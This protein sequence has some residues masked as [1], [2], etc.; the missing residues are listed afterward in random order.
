MYAPEILSAYQ[1]SGVLSDADEELDLRSLIQTRLKTLRSNIAQKKSYLSHLQDLGVDEITDPEERVKVVE[2]R[3]LDCIF[4][5]LETFLLE[6]EAP[7]LATAAARAALVKLLC[8]RMRS[9]SDTDD[10]IV[11]GKRIDVMV[12]SNSLNA[13]DVSPRLLESLGL[14]VAA[15]SL[16]FHSGQIDVALESLR[17]LDFGMQAD[18]SEA[19]GVQAAIDILKEIGN[20]EVL[21]KHSKWLLAAHPQRALAALT[22]PKNKIS[23][24]QPF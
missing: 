6:G 3:A 5:Y 2:K 10:R 11:L 23:L 4:Q 1:F 20:A 8:R 18:A 7:K 19:D 9:A 13:E 17:R 14:F 15:A 12:R 24:L 22:S 16:Q 21:F